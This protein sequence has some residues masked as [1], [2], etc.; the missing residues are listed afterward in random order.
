[1]RKKKSLIRHFIL[2]FTVYTFMRTRILRFL[3]NRASR[4]ATEGRMSVIYQQLMDGLRK[5]YA[6]GALTTF[7]ETKTAFLTG[8]SY[9]F[10]YLPRSLGATAVFRVLST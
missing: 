9:K 7:A 2:V 5:S 1:M 8:I 6:K 10:F 4:R 3:Q